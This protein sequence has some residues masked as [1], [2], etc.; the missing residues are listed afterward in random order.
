MDKILM[1]GMARRSDER[2]SYPQIESAAGIDK[3][4]HNVT[5]IDISRV[6]LRFRSDK[7]YARGEKILLKLQSSDAEMKLSV[8]IK[9]EIVNAYTCKIENAYEYGVK[10]ARVFQWHEMNMIHSFVHLSKIK[11]KRQSR[12]E[13]TYSFNP[14]LVKEPE[15][16]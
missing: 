6:G 13:K 14:F 5:I 16:G 15:E 8:S 12:I 2:L 4:N 3:P 9:G 10:F 11:R 7:R 1:T